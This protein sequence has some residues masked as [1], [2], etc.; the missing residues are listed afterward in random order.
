MTTSSLYGWGMDDR[1]YSLTAEELAVTRAKFA[2]INA[3]AAKQGFEG[4]WTLHATES[5]WTHTGPSGLPVKVHGFDV[6]ISGEAPRL[7][8]GWEFVGAVDFIGG[9]AITRMAPGATVAVENAT[10]RPGE[11]DRCQTVRDRRKTILVHNPE[12]GEV[13]QVGGQCVKDFVGWSAYPSFIDEEEARE[14]IRSAASGIPTSWA[15]V[16]VVAIALAASEAAGSYQGTNAKF[17]TRY[18]VGEVLSG[19]GERAKQA[20]AMVAPYL[21]QAKTAAP[22]VI[23]AVTEA[24]ATANSGYQANLR[25][26]LTADAVT[27]K[28]LALVAS[29]PA[30]WERLEGIRPDP[31]RTAPVNAWLGEVKS[32][33]TVTG[34]VSRVHGIIGEYGTTKLIALETEGGLVTTFTTARWAW[35]PDHPIKTGASLSLTGTVKAHDTYKDRRQTVLTRCKLAT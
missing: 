6:T 21:S 5:V 33:I 22:A 15:V 14:T 12:T 30:A 32:K 2:K 28:T 35:D 8:G 13:L 26:A 10:L 34:T 17:P 18:V 4:R 1:I 23:A 11:C 16:D 9:K 29:T 19:R 27:S 24:F 3:R 7:E 25:I 20:A 31:D